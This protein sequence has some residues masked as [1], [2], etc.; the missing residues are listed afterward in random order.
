[1]SDGRGL[2]RLSSAVVDDERIVIILDSSAHED[3]S[4]RIMAV[5]NIR[6]ISLE[7]ILQL[8]RVIDSH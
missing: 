2:K 4:V 8:W 7:T 3:A 1:M 6:P 5:R